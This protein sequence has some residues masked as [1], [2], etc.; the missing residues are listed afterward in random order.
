MPVELT[1]CVMSHEEGRQLSRLPVGEVKR[2]GVV[3]PCRRNYLHA[4]LAGGLRDEGDVSPEVDWGEVHDGLHASCL[5]GREALDG[6]G[7][8]RRAVEHLR[9]LLE[10][11]PPADADVFVHQREAEVVGVDRPVAD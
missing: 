11:R 6:P 10:H 7:D 8:L 4:R 3:H 9:V 2:D 1:P 5:R